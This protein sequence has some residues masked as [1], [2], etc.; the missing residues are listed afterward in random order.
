MEGE[1]SWRLFEGEHAV[2]KAEITEENHVIDHEAEERSQLILRR[3]HELLC[4]I[5]KYGID[6]LLYL[7]SLFQDKVDPWKLFLYTV[8]QVGKF[9]CVGVSVEHVDG[10]PASSVKFYHLKGTAAGRHCHATCHQ[11]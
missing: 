3:K 10:E 11:L 7:T 2:V 5:V 9:R 8:V 4:L 6:L 1:G